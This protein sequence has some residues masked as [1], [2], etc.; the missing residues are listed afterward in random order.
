M[1]VFTDFI[2][3]INPDLSYEASI[4]SLASTPS[5]IVD[6]TQINN[7]HQFTGLS[8]VTGVFFISMRTRDGEGTLSQVVP[9][10]RS[11]TQPPSAATVTSIGSDH[12]LTTSPT[13]QVSRGGSVY[14]SGYNVQLIK[15]SDN[16]VIYSTNQSEAAL[17]SSTLT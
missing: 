2:I 10:L 9:A 8:L 4:G 3:N 5:D 17:R 1:Q 15:Q 14:R 12:N 11:I 13:V 7:N 16:S 6:W